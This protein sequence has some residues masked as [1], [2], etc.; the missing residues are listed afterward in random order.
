MGKRRAQVSGI[1]PD[2]LKSKLYLCKTSEY[3]AGKLFEEL[4]AEHIYVRHW[5]ARESASI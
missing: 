5:I 2:R 3:D 4:K 1:C